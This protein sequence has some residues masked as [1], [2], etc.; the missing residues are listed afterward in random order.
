MVNGA[1]HL[2]LVVKDTFHRHSF[3]FFYQGYLKFSKHDYSLLNLWYV[4]EV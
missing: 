1:I 3:S 2:A 4:R